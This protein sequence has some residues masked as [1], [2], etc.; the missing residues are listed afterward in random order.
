[1]IILCPT[2]IFEVTYEAGTSRCYP[3]VKENQGRNALISYYSDRVQLQNDAV[4][5]G[6][7]IWSETGERELLVWRNRTWKWT[8]KSGPNEK[9]DVKKW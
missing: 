8:L 1:M 4:Q 2:W 6:Y 7:A 5:C 9:K 3:G